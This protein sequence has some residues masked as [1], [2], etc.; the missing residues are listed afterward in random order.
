MSRMENEPVT[1]TM[2]NETAV[3]FRRVCIVLLTGTPNNPPPLGLA[4]AC[5]QII[6]CIDDAIGA[7]SSAAH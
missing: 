7:E 1:L 4:Q 3:L 6:E 5:Q 2:T